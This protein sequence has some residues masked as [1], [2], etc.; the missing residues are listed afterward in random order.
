M[1]K[2]SK[3]KGFDL[4]EVGLLAALVGVATWVVMYSGPSPSE[5]ESQAFAEQY[6]PG[7]YS[8]NEEEWIIK[9]FFKERR[10]GV[11][12]DVGASHFQ[13][14]SNTYYLETKLGW[15]GLAVEPFTH[16]EP[17][18]RQYRPRTLFAPFF[19]AD[20]S[21]AETKMYTH[22]ENFLANS[23]DRSFVERFGDAPDEVVVRTI[24]LNDL[25][26]RNGIT[27]IDFMSM[28]IELSEPK[29]LAGFDIERFRPE[30]VCIEAHP[31]VRQAILDYFTRHGYVLLG[32]YLRA[33]QKNLYFTP[34]H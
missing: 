4:P 10:D 32:A 16:F 3:T 30:L 9:D 28:D 23:S 27:S 8:E 20:V 2:R 13:I 26:D 19:V 31:E 34:L 15:S 22:G 11:F 18:Y 6:G 25:L 33:D 1:L 17:D 21:G 14:N 7:K 29:A 24:T 12:L 5:L